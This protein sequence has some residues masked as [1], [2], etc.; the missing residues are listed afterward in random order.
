MRS[1]DS[2]CESMA[3]ENLKPTAESPWK[4]VRNLL[5]TDDPAGLEALV[6]SLGHG[7][8]NR[9]LG[10]L[11]EETVT[12]LLAALSAETAADL[13]QDLPDTQAASLI[14]SLETGQAAGI[15]EELGS[16]LGADLLAEL[17][18]ENANAILAQMEPVSA[19]RVR[20]LIHYPEEVA[21]GLM[22]TEEYASRDTETVADFLRH[23]AQ[24]R[25]ERGYLP[26]RIALVD[27][28]GRL[29]GGV[30]IASIL[31]A[32][33]DT[34]LSQLQEAVTPVSDFAS[35]E[36]LDS[37]FQR[38]ETL[39]APVVNA[40]GQLV[41]RL[42]RRAVYERIAENEREAQLKTQGIVSGEEL[43]SM[44]VFFRSR[45]RLS[46]LSLNILLNVMAAS[47]IAFYQ[48]T[49]SAVIALAVFLPI[50]S[51]MSGCSGNQAV[52][53]SLRELT[54]GVVRPG[55]VARVWLKEAAVGVINGSALGLLLGVVAW[56]WQGNPLLG[57]VVGLALGLNTIVA[58]SIGGT[59]PLL[60]KGLRVDP[61]IASGPVLTTVTDMC[62][63]FFVLGLATLALPW[64][65]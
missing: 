56:V 41:G 62:G 44:P 12:R 23:F 5:E 16:D 29:V 49:L 20:Q 8:R 42:R 32:E 40:D 48:D 47:V 65:S 9:A 52:A 18:D 43:R 10:R 53:V 38:H 7:E 58:V 57:L 46:W 24:N 3:P 64:I 4:A 19:G 59:V 61:A 35:L 51:D 63:F 2:E 45:R 31:L 28:A 26:Q 21:G 33:K 22:G 37:Y 1:P 25:E 13:L 14:N 54:L 34:P 11:D 39:G 50:V 17:E 36:E 55:D 6:E 15:V 60:L 30:E 27:D